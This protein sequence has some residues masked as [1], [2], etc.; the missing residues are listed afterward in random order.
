[1]RRST[2]PYRPLAAVGCS[3]RKRSA[4]VASNTPHP[5]CN[6][7][8]V[9][10]HVYI[11][12]GVLMGALPRGREGLAAQCSC[13][14]SS[15]A[16]RHA[17]AARPAAQRARPAAT[18]PAARAA[19]PRSPPTAPPLRPACHSAAQWRCA[20]TLHAR[21]NRCCGGVALCARL[22]ELLCLPLSLTCWASFLTCRLLAAWVCSSKY[23]TAGGSRLDSTEASMGSKAAVGC[24]R[25][26]GSRWGRTQRQAC[27]LTA[28]RQGPPHPPSRRQAAG[29]SA[30]RVLNSAPPTRAQA[31]PA[32]RA[33]PPAAGRAR[34]PPLRV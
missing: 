15:G 5:Y 30:G 24:E 7:W 1:M 18:A 14:S 29:R 31:R 9:P 32:R 17:P 22:A 20:C 2:R 16:P 3:Q 23:K 26:H 28:P 11:N 8:H 19:A 6:S 34:R 21:T 33:P 13:L 27:P 25:R 10:A 4:V 12:D